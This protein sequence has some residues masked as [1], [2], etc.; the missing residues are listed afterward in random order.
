MGPTTIRDGSGGIV[1]R[2]ANPGTYVPFTGIIEGINDRAKAQ[3]ALNFINEAAL[4][5]YVFTRESFLQHRRHLV[6]DGKSEI[7]YD[8]LDLDASFD[9]PTDLKADNSAA[10]ESAAD[11]SDKNLSAVKP[12]DKITSANRPAYDAMIEAFEQNSAKIDRLS[13]IINR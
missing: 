2:A 12:A 1:D 9:D 5:P 10:K 6:N 7:S 3:G 11:E 8:R 13:E 4:D